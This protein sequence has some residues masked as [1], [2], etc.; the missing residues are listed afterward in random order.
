MFSCTLCDFIKKTQSFLRKIQSYLSI[1]KKLTI[2]RSRN[3]QTHTHHSCFSMAKPTDHIVATWRPRN[4]KFPTNISSWNTFK[5]NFS[6]FT[7]F[8]NKFHSQKVFHRK[9]HFQLALSICQLHNIKVTEKC[10]SPLMPLFD[11]QFSGDTKIHKMF[12][13]DIKWLQTRVGPCPW[14]L[15]QWKVNGMLNS[16]TMSL[17][18]TRYCV[19]Q[20]QF[21]VGL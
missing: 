18:G 11:E 3:F 12:H 9:F 21:V 13:E 2:N 10:P 17:H 6:E 15:S 5:L 1:N 7:K 16:I 20:F 8:R 4:I 14:F 19:F